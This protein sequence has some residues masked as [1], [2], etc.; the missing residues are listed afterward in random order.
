MNVVTSNRSLKIASVDDCQVSQ[1]AIQYHLEKA[2]LSA[3]HFYDGN[4]AINTLN[5]KKFD[6][7]LLDL[8]IRKFDGFDILKLI[9]NNK[10]SKNYKSKIFI[11]TSHK[12]T[13]KIQKCLSNGADEYLI[14]PLYV[15]DFFDLINKYFN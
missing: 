9:K 11:I 4:E 2:N 13:E 3:T 8:E 12:S 5:S 1:L 10:N 7:I 6:L 14:K 15:R